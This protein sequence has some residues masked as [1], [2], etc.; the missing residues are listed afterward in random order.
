MLKCAQCGRAGNDIGDCGSPLTCPKQGVPIE[1]GDVVLH[2]APCDVTRV[3][4]AHRAITGKALQGSHACPRGEAH[5][6]CRAVNDV[7]PA[8]ERP[9]RGK[10]PA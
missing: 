10:K 4:S 8:K 1:A 2:C 3:V 6:A 9:A 5:C 7:E